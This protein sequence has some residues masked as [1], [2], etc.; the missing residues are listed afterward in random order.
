[1]QLDQK[2]DVT[3]VTGFFSIRGFEHNV[4][5]DKFASDQSYFE[6]AEKLL[7][8]NIKLV[9]FIEPH[10]V[11]W[12]YETRLLACHCTD[13]DACNHQHTHTIVQRI[14]DLPLYAYYNEYQEQFNQGRQPTNYDPLKF[15][16]LYYLLI[17]CK[18]LW[19]S[20]AM[21]EN[22]FATTHY[23]WL[24]FRLMRLAMHPMPT[25]YF[26]Q[27]SRR[28]LQTDKVQMMMMYYGDNMP[29]RNQFYRAFRGEIAG[30]MLFGHRDQLALFVERYNQEWTWLQSNR[31]L[32]VS[33]EMIYGQLANE[34]GSLAF[35]FFFGDYCQIMEGALGFVHPHVANQVRQFV[36]DRAKEREDHRVVAQAALH[37]IETSKRYPDLMDKNTLFHL[38]YSRFLSCFYL[39]NERE[40]GSVDAALQLIQLAQTRQDMYDLLTRDK[41]DFVKTNLGYLHN[42]QVDQAWTNLLS[43][44]FKVN[45]RT[46]NESTD[47]R[48][49]KV[50]QPTN[51]IAHKA[52]IGQ[53]KNGQ[54]I[55][56]MSRFKL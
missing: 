34:Y 52:R 44:P 51:Q 18:P 2:K 28:I 29:D 33:E 27:L 49:Q 38:Y 35:D 32:C 19:M 54:C 36:L 56:R 25:D 3:Y 23:G 11:D 43:E 9:I 42:E 30:G 14:E 22:P 16:A 50:K 1:M 21:Q 26:D 40:T 20:R 7:E 55:K 8:Q 31:L 39:P 53:A 46:I 24:D 4:N 47:Q 48:A 37:L 10:R 17:Q 45:P 13:K 5:K 6:W 12:V 15:T 41:V